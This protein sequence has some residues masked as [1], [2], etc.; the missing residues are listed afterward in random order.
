[1]KRLILVIAFLLCATGAQAQVSFEAGSFL[2]GT[3]T[4]AVEVNLAGAF[5]PKVVC[6]FTTYPGNS[7]DGQN[8]YSISYGCM[9]DEATDQ[10]RAIWV[11]CDDSVDPSDCNRA[12]SAA[13]VLIVYNGGTTLV[14]D[15]QMTS[16]DADGFTVTPVDAFTSDTTVYFWALG[17]ADITN[18]SLHT[19]NQA[20]SN[21]NFSSTTPGF[22]PD[23]LMAFGVPNTAAGTGTGAYLGLGMTDGTNAATSCVGAEDAQVA[24]VTVNYLR[25]AAAQLEFFSLCSSGSVFVRDSFVSFDA[26]GYTLNAVEQDGTAYQI[27]MLAIKG[28]QWTVG[29]FLSQ[30]STGNFTESHG[31]FTGKGLFVI[32]NHFR[33]AQSTVDTTGT[34][35]ELSLGA[36]SSSTARFTAWAGAA[37]G[38]NEN[39]IYK[40]VQDATAISANYNSAT[41]PAVQGDIDFVSFASG[42][43]TLNQTDADILQLVHTYFVVGDSGAAPATGRRRNQV[44]Q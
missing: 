26:N 21:G 10:Q 18:V 31:A 8:G 5:Q 19:L 43:F 22:E 28:G 34:G 32:G 44:I 17:G 3:G 24:S 41:P 25:T 40:N 7:A 9:T 13:R 36:A 37:N 33:T 16:F 35:A 14:G 1:M 15:L 23:F 27:Y 39:D 11:G 12:S 20:T 38:D 4:T 29:D 2:T 42:Q 30:T 6:F